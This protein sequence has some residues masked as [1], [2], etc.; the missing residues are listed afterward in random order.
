MLVIRGGTV[1][2]GTGVPGKLADVGINGDTIAVIGDLS[3]GGQNRV[4]AKGMAV[5]PGFINM[6]SHAEVSL[7]FDGNSQSDIRQGLH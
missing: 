4:K 3:G 6:M 7:L 5:T 2:D 1:Y